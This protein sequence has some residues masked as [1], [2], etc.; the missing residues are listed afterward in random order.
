MRM[1]ALQD[2]ALYASWAFHFATTFTIIAG[3]IVAVGGKLFQY[4]DKGLIF[5]YYLLC[6]CVRA[7]MW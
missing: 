7:W 4:S 3:L 2:S 6:A 5:L 1:M